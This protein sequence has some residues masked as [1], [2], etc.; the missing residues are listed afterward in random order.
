VGLVHDEVVVVAPDDHAAEVEDW[1]GKIMRTVGEKA[2]NL[3]APEGRRVPVEAGT[4]IC[5]TWAEK[6]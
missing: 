1:L 4:K 3:D 2:T 5:R 6:E